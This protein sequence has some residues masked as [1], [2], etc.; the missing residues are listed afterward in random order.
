MATATDTYT[1]DAA[2]EVLSD[3]QQIP[4]LTPTVTLTSQ[5][6]A[7][8][9]TQLSAVVGTEG[10]A[11]YDF[12][13]TYQYA[14]FGGQMS[15]VTQQS[16]SGTL[17][18]GD[19]ADAVAAKTVTF[20]YDRLGEFSVVSRYQHADATANL[21]ATG[22]Y[23]YNRAGT[24]A[25]ID[26]ADASSNTLDNFTWTYDA[27]ADVATSDSS[28]DGPNGTVTY[29]NDSTGQLTGASGG[30]A[31]TESYSYDSNGNRTNAGYVTGADNEL[32]SDGTYDYQY[33]AEGNRIARWVP[34]GFNETAPG[35]NTGDTDITLYTW[36]N[37]N[38]LTSVT[39]YANYNDVH[40][41][42]QLQQPDA[43]ND[44]QLHLRR[45]QPLDRRDDHQL[46]EWRRHVG[47]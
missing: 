20:Q 26:Y 17:P 31:P 29:A 41:H 25:S 15:Q 38:R 6:T 8:N 46:L 19:T 42:G 18:T 9:R 30:Q 33:D 5:Y 47:Q 2:G 39:T 16:Y 24:L 4:G 28:L 23:S 27:L 21:V 43:R 34:G 40:W 32:L 37:R 36:D 45:V 22:T 11:D 1:Y 7:G 3:T 35:Q 44:G 14:G 12:V 13:N 10:S